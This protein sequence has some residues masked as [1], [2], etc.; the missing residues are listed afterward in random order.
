MPKARQNNA[1]SATRLF[2]I[3][4]LAALARL[5]P[6]GGACAAALDDQSGLALLPSPVRIV[7][8]VEEQSDVKRAAKQ[9][10]AL[11]AVAEFIDSRNENP[12]E[13]GAL[14]PAA[15]QMRGK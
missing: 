9:L 1:A 5:A 8:D 10:A 14:P 15:V 11:V 6:T 13:A 7:S 3:G 4:F 2:R 12:A